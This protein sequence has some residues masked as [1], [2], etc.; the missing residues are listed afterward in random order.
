MLTQVLVAM[1]M[2]EAP[3][4]QQ[5]WHSANATPHYCISQWKFFGAAT[6]IMNNFSETSLPRGGRVGQTKTLAPVPPVPLLR[7]CYPSHPR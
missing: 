7:P 4:L 6:D 5:Q 3:H 1:T 2:R